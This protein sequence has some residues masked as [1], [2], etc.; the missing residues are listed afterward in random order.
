MVMVLLQRK[1]HQHEVYEHGIISTLS[2]EPQ[3][4]L[5]LYLHEILSISEVRLVTE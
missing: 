1:Q 4:D 5:G 2:D 3:H